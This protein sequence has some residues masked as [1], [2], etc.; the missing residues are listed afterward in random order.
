MDIEDRKRH[1]RV[2]L[3]V[4]GCIVPVATIG[5]IL[6]FFVWGIM[7][8]GGEASHDEVA[9]V[10][11]PSGQMEAVLV[12]S[13]GGATTSFWYDVYLVSPGW[14]Y[15]NGIHLAYLYGAV[16]SNRAYGVNLK[17]SGPET[18]TLEYLEAKQARL[19][20]PNPT[21]EGESITVVLKSGVDDSKV[22]G[23]GMGYNLRP[24]KQ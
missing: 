10:P 9:R 3:I 12:E 17:W 4:F 2:L 16:R 5:A 22:P 18:L 20:N 7:L 14:A 8:I 6:G 1:K 19:M 11:S 13:N 15:T 23:G 24:K 21:I